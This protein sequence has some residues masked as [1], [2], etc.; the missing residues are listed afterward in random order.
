M[1]DNISLRKIWE[2]ETMFEVIFR[3]E[4]DRI[5]FEKNL[6][7]QDYL[8]QEFAAMIKSYCDEFNSQIEYD[9][10]EDDYELEMKIFPINNLNKK[11]YLL[12]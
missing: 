12:I 9:Y 4:N 6:Y 2:D 5:S 1:K 8:I 7:M 11:S 3:V 10:S